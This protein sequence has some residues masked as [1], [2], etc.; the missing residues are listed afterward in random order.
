MSAGTVRAA[1]RPKVGL[2]RLS[3]DSIRPA[4]ENSLVYGPVSAADPGIRALAR[5]IEDHGLREPIVVTADRYILSGHRRHAACRLAG[6][7]EVDCRVEPISRSDPEFERLLVEY[8][9]QRVKSFDEV[10]R[11]QVIDSEIDP[12]EAYQSL[13]TH[14]AEKAAVS[15]A[16][17]SLGTARKR[18]KITHLK[19]PMLEA[20]QSVVYTEKDFWP[21][22]DRSTHYSLLNDPPLRNA[23]NPDSRYRNDRDCYKDTCDM[24]TRARLVGEIPFAAIEDPTREVECWEVFREVGGYVRVAL[25]GFLQGYCRDLQQSQPNHIEIVG[26]KNTIAGSIRRVAAK[27]CIPYTIGR[28]YSSLDPRYKMF[29]RFLE[30]GKRRLIIL[31]QA[32]FDPEGD[33]APESFAESMRDDFGVEPLAIKVALTYEQVLERELPVDFGAIK[34]KSSRYKKF[35]AKYGEDVHVHELEALASAERSRLLDEAI[36]GVMDLD[37]YNAEVEAE[38]EE[39]P[40]LARL[41]KRVGPMIRAALDEKTD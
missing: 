19:R 33:N 28:G 40:R 24:L 39:A 29:R 17:L 22:S 4:P 35:V 18:K 3:L 5:S 38:R 11:E 27:Y 41:R 31:F 21:L 16:F 15:G 30:S 9:R 37:A 1:A 13:L 14:R 12:A 34:K 7:R 23:R 25:D 32:D 6:L 26:E 20:I 2:V 10:I 36:R 8:N